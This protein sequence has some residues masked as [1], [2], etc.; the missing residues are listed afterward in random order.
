MWSEPL[1]IVSFV[2]LVCLVGGGEGDEEC[3]GVEGLGREVGVGS[4]VL[5]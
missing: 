4:E 5:V 3:M 2:E 1:S